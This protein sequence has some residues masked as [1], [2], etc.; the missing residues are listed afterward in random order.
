MLDTPYSR[1]KNQKGKLTVTD[2]N[3]LTRTI[4]NQT[5]VSANQLKQHIEKIERL[6]EEKSQIQEH[7]KDAFAHAK[8]DGFDVKIMRQVIRM[9]KLKREELLE[10]QELIEVYAQA[11]GMNLSI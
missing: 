2:P 10:Q 3:S 5:G 9:R 1:S 4:E 8:L 7:I 6:E 11:L